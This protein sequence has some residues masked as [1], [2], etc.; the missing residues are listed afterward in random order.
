MNYRETGNIYPFNYLGHVFFYCDEKKGGDEHLQLTIGELRK[1]KRQITHLYDGLAKTV[2]TIHREVY[3]ERMP[4]NH[5]SRQEK[6][7]DVLAKELGCMVARF[8]S[9]AQRGQLSCTR[10]SM[11]RVGLATT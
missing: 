1:V 11:T 6:Y 10:T 8:K 3:E 7:G 5:Q 9:H 4:F 2:D